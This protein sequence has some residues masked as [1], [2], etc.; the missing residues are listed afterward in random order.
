M[1]KLYISRPQVRVASFLMA[2]MES[3]AQRYLLK[4]PVLAH[5][6]SSRENAQNRQR[7]RICLLVIYRLPLGKWFKS[8]NFID[9]NG[10]QLVIS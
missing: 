7:L 10:P 9:A 5:G 1:Q 4:Q 8:G 2:S 6:M 3:A